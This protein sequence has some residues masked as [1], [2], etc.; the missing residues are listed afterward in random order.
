MLQRLDGR[1][2]TAFHINMKTAK[3]LRLTNPAGAAAPH[4]SDHRIARGGFAAALADRSRSRWNPSFNFHIIRDTTEGGEVFEY[5]I[6]LSEGR[7]QEDGRRKGQGV[8][9]LFVRAKERSTVSGQMVSPRFLL[10]VPGSDRS[11]EQPVLKYSAG[12]GPRA[13][14]GS[15]GVEPCRSRRCFPLLLIPP[16]GAVGLGGDPQETL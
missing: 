14:S 4:G 10:G 9:V 11:R 15:H 7:G 3:A 8:D 16:I 5:F 12:R 6:V 2:V 1:G 13:Q